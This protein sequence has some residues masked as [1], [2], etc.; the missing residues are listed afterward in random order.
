MAFHI[1]IPLSSPPLTI[2]GEKNKV[3]ILLSDDEESEVDCEV[4]ENIGKVGRKRRIVEP[5]ICDKWRKFIQEL[6][7]EYLIIWRMR[8]TDINI[9]P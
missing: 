3:L 7:T 1:D 9:V 2:E 5:S 8:D 4:V 6:V